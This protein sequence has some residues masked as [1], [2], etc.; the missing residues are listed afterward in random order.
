MPTS[1][2]R[3]AEPLL[4]AE[5]GEAQAPSD[6]RFARIVAAMQPPPPRA[7]RKKEAPPTVASDESPADALARAWALVRSGE[8]NAGLTLCHQVWPMVSSAND[9][10]QMGICQYVL[11]LGYHYHGMFKAAL[12]AGH[13]GLD[14]LTRAG[15]SGRVLH[16][17]SMHAVTLSNL[18]Q[19]TESFELLYRGTQLLSSVSDDPLM[20]CRFWNNAA[21][22]YSSIDRDDQALW[23]L[24]RSLAL[25]PYLQD[26]MMKGLVV[27]N[28][29]GAR[30]AVLIARQAGWDE[31]QPAYI[32]MR[33]HLDEVVAQGWNHVVVPIV[34]VGA[35]ALTRLGQWDE[36]RTILRI[37]HKAT[38]APGMEGRRARVE[39]CLA[40]LER[41][42]GQYRLASVH[43]KEALSLLKQQEDPVL[44]AE[45]HLENCLLQEAQGHLRTALASLREHAKLREA[46]LTA[47]AQ[48]RSDALAE[49]VT[50]EGRR[51]Y[52]DLARRHGDMPAAQAAGTAGL[53]PDP[54]QGE[55]DATP[56]GLPGR[57][58]FEERI[59]EWQSAREPGTPLVL[60]ICSVDQLKAISAKFTAPRSREVLRA[61]GQLLR[62]H[63]RPNDAVA[64]WDGEEFV[65]GFGGGAPFEESIQAA[66]RVR[67]IIEQHG[68]S[69]IAPGL[70]VTAS[71][72][73]TA[74]GDG[75]DMSDAMLRAAWALHDAKQGGR[76]QVRAM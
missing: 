55:F 53:A 4:E 15:D 12:T 46:W 56:M 21:T 37:A 24:E 7:G 19:V 43:A 68:W 31:V 72:G 62:K 10:A 18:G 22:L 38:M 29:H 26:P 5:E 51:N 14:L 47:Q 36:A 1:S 33:R 25:S 9:V 54:F 2:E 57:Q 66:N 70:A 48:S 45:V 32:D 11:V 71:F 30:M 3:P 50:L 69:A 34:V 61:V 23:C 65:V 40:Q 73:L 41:Q 60:M 42:A 67:D 6:D 76:S 49:R 20:Q 8:V 44:L 58:Q 35:A 27:G 28:V 63:L 13:R 74:F 17:I 64:S 52:A 39:L 59:G 16:L 75:E